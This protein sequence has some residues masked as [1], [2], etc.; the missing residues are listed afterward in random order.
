MA[1][2][3]NKQMTIVDTGVNNVEY[4]HNVENTNYIC[5]KQKEGYCLCSDIYGVVHTF[6]KTPKFIKY[7]TYDDRNCA[8]ICIHDTKLYEISYEN[9]ELIIMEYI[10][11][12]NK[13]K[14]W[15]NLTVI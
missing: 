11:E 6:K 7:W 5:V 9:N 3:Q 12:N 13:Y 14:P 4:I 10:L 15:A 2:I 1:N 8:L